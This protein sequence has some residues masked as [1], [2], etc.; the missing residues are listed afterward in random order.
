MGN[1]D[2]AYFMQRAHEERD[3][4]LQNPSTSAAIFYNKLADAYE[5]RA[6]EAQMPGHD[7]Q[8]VALI[9]FD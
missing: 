6:R 4:A 9:R 2:Q 3:R 7:A 5:Q 1:L 8:P